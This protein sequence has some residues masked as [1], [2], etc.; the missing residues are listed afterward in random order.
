MKA[1]NRAYLNAVFGLFVLGILCA[2][3]LH[4][5]TLQLDEQGASN[6]SSHMD[7]LVDPGTNLELT[8]VRSDQ[9][10]KRWR[11][12]TDG[13]VNLGF[14]K[15]AYWFRF[16]LHNATPRAAARLLELSYPLLDWISIYELDEQG[17]LQEA[18]ETGDH[19]PFNQRFL[20]YKTFVFPI[21][22]PAE[23]TRHFYIRVKTTS[24]LQVPMVLW[25]K[26][27]F[28]QLALVEAQWNMLY[29]GVIIAMI[30]V[31]L[32]FLV[33][34]KEIMYLWYIGFV[35]SYALL[36]A[37]LNGIAYQ[38]LWPFFP[39]LQ[40]YSVS[41][42][43]PLC[44]LF[45][46]LFTRE[47]LV[48]KETAPRWDWVLVAILLAAVFCLVLAFVLDYQYA[49]RISAVMTLPASVCVLAIGPYLW[50]N[51]HQVARF[52]SLAWIVMMLGTAVL[53]LSKLGVF[54]R[55]FFSEYVFQVGSALEA[56]L[57][58]IALADRFN[59]ERREKLA[60]QHAALREAQQRRQLENSML[61]QATHHP[62]TGMPNAVFLESE[63]TRR[64]ENKPLNAFAVVL[65]HLG[66]F[67]E[68]NKTL[69]HES[70]DRLLLQF[71]RDFKQQTKQL[72]SISPINQGKSETH[73]IAA[74]E[75]VTFALVLNESDHQELAATLR[76]LIYG[77]QKP[78]VFNGMQIVLGCRVGVAVY[79]EHS[80][81]YAPLVRQA[82]VAMDAPRNATALPLTV[83]SQ[84]IDSYNERRLALMGELQKAIAHDTLEMYFQP[85]YDLQADCVYGLEALVRWNHRD[86]GFVP[87]DEFVP[88]A[89]KSG[90]IQELT[91]WVMKQS[92]ATY[93]TLKEHGF[94]LS[95]SINI[96]A[97]NLSETDFAEFTIAQLASLQVPAD[98][99]TLEVTETAV[100]TDLFN[101]VK[102]LQSIK[103]TGVKV[104]IDDFGTGYSSLSYI[105]TLP[106]AEIKIDKSL[107]FDMEH[108]ADNR[109]IVKTAVDMGH[110][111]GYSVV[112]E[113]VE[114]EHTMLDLKAMKCDCMQGYFLSKPLPL[115]AL[116]SW[117]RE[118]EA[119]AS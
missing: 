46:S 60:A 111:L 13:T 78:L 75:G 59:I 25:K 114:D 34:L 12:V 65:V 14:R 92:L 83:Y 54:P 33:T 4:A 118:R 8:D 26:D 2:G 80:K 17:K 97:I 84:A 36:V 43:V 109:V 6:L 67:H 31:N 5:R 40:D 53:A 20:N 66:R 55:N 87:P 107:I 103:D 64:I 115:P 73:Y 82:Q 96:S 113:G 30:L 39:L 52:F 32:F 48:T 50:A 51:G 94:D 62:R 85:K 69:G 35:A 41:T 16:S 58:T 9:M 99:V 23:S 112:A 56:V 63:I 29:F 42:L 70:A 86:F 110:G 90:V 89:E 74:V 47:F 76:E 45:G 10:S 119:K 117:L 72:P 68:I 44:A 27:A 81:S 49:I 104:S 22:L 18:F 91:R 95:I 3:P 61:H 105:K 71:L 102:I 57:L 15:E 19:E 108:S 24:S 7:Y 21:N 101:M 93:L 88:L 38:Y 37:A 77:V 79:P 100:S 116:V 1:L 28:Y 98:K 106:V 11:Y